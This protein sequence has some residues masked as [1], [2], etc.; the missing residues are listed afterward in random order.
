MNIIEKYKYNQRLLLY[1]YKSKKIK[2]DE[3]YLYELLNAIHDDLVLY[4]KININ[5]NDFK[6][7]K[8]CD[9]FVNEI[10]SLN[11][12]PLKIDY[13]TD[14]LK[15][16]KINEKYYILESYQM[17]HYNNKSRISYSDISKF[18]CHGSLMDVDKMNLVCL[19]NSKICSMAELLLQKKNVN[20]IRRNIFDLINS[21][22]IK[23]ILNK[24]E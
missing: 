19:E 22:K 17:K 11:R 24:L 13:G 23:N 2:L 21:K 10:S 12:L 1:L 18:I 5:E 8:I 6:I 14:A 4:H 15:I 16:E 9:E 3:W 7:N 20:I